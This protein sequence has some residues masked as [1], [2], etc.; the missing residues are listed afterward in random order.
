[1]PKK[2]PA[3]YNAIAMP[4]VLSVLMSC[5]VSAVST[6]ANAGFS[7]D[8]FSLWLKAWGTSWLVAFPSLLLVLPLVRFIVA[9]IVQVP[10]AKR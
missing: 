1:M 6:A 4:Q 7:A 8:L 3:R 10:Q 9:A 5:I 2:L